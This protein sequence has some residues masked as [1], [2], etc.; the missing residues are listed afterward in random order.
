MV[1]AD[2]ALRIKSAGAPAGPAKAFRQGTHRT[3]SPGETVRRVA[4]FLRTLGITR[5]ANV[6]GLDYVGI[7]VV[8]S[9]RPNSCNLSVYQGK[10]VTLDAAKAS[11]VMEAYEYACAEA[12][13]ADAIWAGGEVHGAR[14][15]VPRRAQQRRL[16]KG[17]EIPW[18]KG[19]DLLSGEAV[20]VP[21][22]TVSTDLR[23]PPRRGFGAFHRTS[24]GLASGNTQDEALLHAICELIE[25]DAL[26]LW[27]L[28]PPAHR[29]ATRIAPR[30][31]E[32]A[33]VHAL[34]D[35]Y[36]AAAMRVQ[37]WETTS[38][39][40]VPACFCVIDDADA[41]PP[42]L[43]RFGG[44]GCHPDADVAMCRALTE[45]AQSR[46][47]FI[48][49]TR[50]DIPPASYAM[51]G[52]ERSIANLIAGERSGERANGRG[53][54]GGSF[55]ADTVGGDVEAVLARLAARGIG[56]VVHVDLTMASVAMPCA[57]VLIPELEG[58]SHWAGYRA[59]KRAQQAMRQWR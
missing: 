3:C 24:N 29:A 13:R 38:D 51:T 12:P 8:M 4:P 21:E 41:E 28:S 16:R 55:A 36:D 48:V 52:W 9:V 56:C 31:S 11:A 27:K 50:D 14:C 57:R 26:T 17:S 18:V 22:E 1:R 10:G 30:R 34:M 33:S 19:A 42:Y 23:E 7:P 35:C 54:V 45:A 40:G 46:L 39:I 44:A 47:T 58:A 20:W 37:L 15:L 32:D 53:V 5:V 43:G 2:G 49:G 25:R 6:T 59:G